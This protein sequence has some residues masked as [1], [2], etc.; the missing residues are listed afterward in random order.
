MNDH[1]STKTKKLSDV[2]SVS[3]FAPCYRPQCLKNEEYDLISLTQALLF[4]LNDG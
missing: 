4:P 1:K 2:N 3:K